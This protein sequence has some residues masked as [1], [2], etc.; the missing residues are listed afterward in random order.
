MTVLQGRSSPAPPVSRLH[1]RQSCHP[2][3]VPVPTGREEAWRL[4]RCAASAGGR[5]IRRCPSERSPCPHPRWLPPVPNG[6]SPARQRLPARRPGQCPR[7]RV[8]RG[9]DSDHRARR[10]GGVPA[11]AQRMAATPDGTLAT[12]DATGRLRAGT[13]ASQSGACG[14]AHWGCDRVDV[15]FHASAFS[16]LT[17]VI[18]PR[19]QNARLVQAYWATSIGRDCHQRLNAGWSERNPQEAVDHPDCAKQPDIGPPNET[20]VRSVMSD[21]EGSDPRHWLAGASPAANSK[22]HS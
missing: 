12:G 13:L 3:D 6:A 9:G 19:Y 4:R 7:L 5:A 14:I 17:S 8:L 16:Y 22:R 1:E 15:V 11:D 21:A 10:G 2:A 18:S 20:T